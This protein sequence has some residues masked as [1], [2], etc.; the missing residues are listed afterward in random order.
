M[1]IVRRVNIGQSAQLDTLALECGKL[2]S[3][4]V[5]W[6]WRF[7]RH[8]GVWLKPSSMMRFLNSDNLHAH[9]SD[10]CV[11]TFYASLK[12]WKILRKTDPN[13]KPPKRRRKY[14]RTEYKNSAIRHIDGKLVLSN[15]RGNEPLIIPWPWNTPRTV[16]IR[17]QGAQYEAIATYEVGKQA[18]PKGNKVAG[19]DLGEIHIAVSH[20]GEK[21]TIL[22]GRWLRAK[23]R[24]QN[25]IKARLS[26]LIDVKQ[27]GS[28]RRR[29][30]IKSKRK[31][32]K[33]LDNQIK[34][35]LHKQTTHLVCTLHQEGVQTVVIGDIRDIRKDLDYGARANQKIHQM[36][37][38]QTRHMLTYKAER[39][40][41]MVRLQEESYTSQAC[42]A[43]PKKHK[44]SGRLYRC[45][46][47]FVYHRDGVGSFNIRKKYLGVIPVVGVMAPPTGLRYSPHTRVAQVCA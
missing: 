36:V 30:F 31:Q 19:I 42:P 6:F 46:C 12:S 33:K 2:Y 15:G 38:G 24:Y 18:E 39:K 14:F 26:S 45:K 5:T 13:A 41:M 11:Q 20:D 7:V 9:T 23:R 17:W 21:C 37:H 4:T 43:C 1:Y 3:L 25:K 32:L 35:I 10:A 28:R 16:V 8:K 40:G 47:G 44:P 29:K 22:N 34:D 27:K